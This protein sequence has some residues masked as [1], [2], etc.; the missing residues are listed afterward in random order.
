MRKPS[1][2]KAKKIAWDAFSKFIRLRDD[3][4]GCFTCPARKPWKQM[5]A[6]HFIPGRHNSVLFDERNCHSQCPSCNVFLHGNMIEYYPRMLEKYGQKVID[7]LRLRD[8]REIVQLKIYELL[9]IAEKYSDLAKTYG[10]N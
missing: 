7:E 3:L 9:L 10:E 4:N 5:Q 2:S 6:G 8:K 1:Y